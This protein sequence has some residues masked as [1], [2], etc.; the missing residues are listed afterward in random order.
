[1]DTEVRE[2]IE[3]LHAW[4]RMVS[5]A[6]AGAGTQAVGWILGVAGASRTVLTQN[7]IFLLRFSLTSRID[8]F[9]GGVLAPAIG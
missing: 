1:M 4:E 3:S 8:R 2:L 9:A 6:I 5:L 7:L